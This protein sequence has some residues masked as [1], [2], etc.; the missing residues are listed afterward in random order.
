MIKSNS[1]NTK[2]NKTIASENVKIDRSIL[3]FNEI[4]ITV[5]AWLNCFAKSVASSKFYSAESKASVY[6]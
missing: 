4:T 1:N 6:V 2:Q 5:T 3:I